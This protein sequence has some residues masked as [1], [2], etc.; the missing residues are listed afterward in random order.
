MRKWLLIKGNNWLFRDGWQG[1]RMNM[2]WC[3][4][5]WHMTHMDTWHVFNKHAF[6]C[7]NTTSVDQRQHGVAFDN[8][9]YM[10]TDVLTKE[11]C[12]MWH[13]TC[14]DI[15]AQKKT[16]VNM[17]VIDE[18]L[19]NS[20]LDKCNNVTHVD[21]REHKS[22]HVT[23]CPLTCGDKLQEVSHVTVW[24]HYMLRWWCM[25]CYTLWCVSVPFTGKNMLVCFLWHAN[26]FS[27]CVDVTT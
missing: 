21:T 2:H 4:T 1:P 22:C 27:G 15:T 7:I 11:T 10:L 8:C 16:S 25:S 3:G 17:P 6:T 9:W 23:Q 26:C 24:Q 12:D 5:A 19:H 14:H 13:H 18:H 20:R